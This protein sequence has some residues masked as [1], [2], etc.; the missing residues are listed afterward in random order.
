MASIDTVAERLCTTITFVTGLRCT[1]ITDQ[2][3]PPCVI[4]YPDAE[5]GG[6]TYYEAFKRGVCT[7]PFVAQ[8]LVPSTDMRG[9]QK[10]LNGII[11]PS[12]ATSIPAAIF[13]APT[14]GT[15]ATESPADDATTMTAHVTRVSEYGFTGDPG[16]PRWLSAKVHIEVMVRGDT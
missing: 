13:A 9:A 14:L 8:I 6:E 15:S 5:I 3:N 4:V 2:P 10:V 12:G 11:S 16:N 1:Q 7:L